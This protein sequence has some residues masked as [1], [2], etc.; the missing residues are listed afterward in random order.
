MKRLEIFSLI[1][2]CVL[3][4]GGG[5]ERRDGPPV[6]AETEDADYRRAQQL[7]RQ[8]RN[9]EA[10]VSYLK[11]IGRRGDEAP[12]SHFEAGLLFM[13]H[14]KDH[15]AAIYH[16][17][18]YVELRPTAPQ[19]GLVRGRID[20]AKREFAR[21]LPIDPL[22]NQAPRLD[23]MDQIDRLRR[24]VD[25]LKTELMVARTGVPGPVNR[26]LVSTEAGP[27]APAAVDPTPIRV[28]TPV[29]EDSPITMAPL[30]SR[31]VTEP[32]PPETRAAPTAPA[33][34]RHTVVKGD[35]LFSLA[36]RYYSNRSRWREIY[37]ANRDQ[38]PSENALRLGMEITIP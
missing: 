25:Q 21:T 32:V 27:G 37:E 16:F 31:S 17:R 2:L 29:P 7:K 9:Q 26:M 30:P 36:Q 24:E 4:W 38:M 11:V 33:G 6:G 1:A 14:A 28:E 8:G 13:E 10:L 22:E 12:E 20:A 23:M 19:A 3:L 5:C 15:L 35:T 18:K 34:R